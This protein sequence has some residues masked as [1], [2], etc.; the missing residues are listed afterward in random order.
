MA[1]PEQE[2]LARGPGAGDFGKKGSASVSSRTRSQ[3]CFQ[4][5]PTKRRRVN[6][7]CAEGN[8]GQAGS[9]MKELEENRSV[10]IPVAGA[11]LQQRE[12]LESTVEGAALPLITCEVPKRGCRN[13]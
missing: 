6:T 1:P 9:P 4:G 12:E 7:T 13:P 2:G 10:S 11:Q 3:V 8:L 5:W